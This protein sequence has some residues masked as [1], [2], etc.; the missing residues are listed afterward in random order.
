MSR[1]NNEMPRTDSEILDDFHYLAQ[2][3]INH[4][5]ALAPQPMALNVTFFA[6][7]GMD[8][9]WDSPESAPWV[10]LAT[11]VRKLAILEDEA[12]S[13][14]KVLKI[15]GK[16]HE[17]LRPDVQRIQD[18]VKEWRGSNKAQFVTQEDEGGLSITSNAQAA[19][20]VINGSMF[21][22]NA[23]L[24]KV[25]RELDPFARNYMVASA[26]D[27]ITTAAGLVRQTVDVV[28]RALPELAAAQ[29]KK[30]P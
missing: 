21:H 28:E 7:G 22:G 30:T 17:W 3:V 29:T 1:R 16:N 26:Q 13:I 23:N 2:D 18:A 14:T 25:W 6:G 5:L 12:T 10:E 9:G 8:F 19:E 20:I 27:W 11:Y 24:L 4:P 15:M